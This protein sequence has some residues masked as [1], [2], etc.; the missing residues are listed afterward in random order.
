ME[1]ILGIVVIYNPDIEKLVKNINQYIKDVSVLII[2]QNSLLSFENRNQILQDCA[3]SEKII[4]GGSG[5]N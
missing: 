1:G 3:S 5:S 4:F 2:W